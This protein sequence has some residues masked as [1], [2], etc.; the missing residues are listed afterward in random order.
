MPRALGTHEV[1]NRPT[2]APSQS[3]QKENS[4]S[5]SPLSDPGSE[6]TDE[7]AFDEP[8]SR[9]DSTFDS[10]QRSHGEPHRGSQGGADREQG[11]EEHTAVA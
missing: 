5:T 2:A 3:S 10:E 11:Y 4:S 9:V 1:P 7:S 8:G 6:L